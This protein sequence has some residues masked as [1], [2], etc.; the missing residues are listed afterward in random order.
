MQWDIRIVN[1]SAK[2]G[3]VFTRRGLIPEQNSL[4][5]LPRLVGMGRAMELL[6]T[7][8]IFSGAEA[9]DY[10]LATEAVPGDDVL[11]RAMQIA[12]DIARHTAPAAVGITKQLAYELLCR[13]RPGSGVL[14]RV[15]GVPLARAPRRRDRRGGVVPGTSAAQIRVFPSTFRFRTSDR[16]WGLDE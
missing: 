9:K 2:Y 16:G 12:D 4:W 7:G 14:S 1:E 13:D 3:F 15:G 10:G 6:M 5:L 8:R 11:P